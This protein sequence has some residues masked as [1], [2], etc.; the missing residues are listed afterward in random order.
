VSSRISNKISIM[1]V[2]ARASESVSILV[3]VQ[4]R[5]LTKSTSLSMPPA[6]K[7][8]VTAHAKRHEMSFS[9]FVTIL[10]VN[11][12]NAVGES[13][14]GTERPKDEAAVVSNEPKRN[15]DPGASAPPNA[16][17]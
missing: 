11:Y 16:T 7:R 9:E 2:K 3:P 17:Q 8:M 5:E 12:L 6:V 4:R 14:P 10:C 13:E 1:T 15:T